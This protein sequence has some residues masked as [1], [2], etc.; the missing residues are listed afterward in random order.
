MGMTDKQ[1]DAY[2]VSQLQILEGIQDR[3]A[4]QG[5]KDSELDRLIKSLQDQLKRP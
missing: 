5:V 1:F 3:L 2:T 4:K